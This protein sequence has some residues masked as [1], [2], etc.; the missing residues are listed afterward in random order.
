[1]RLHEK[2]WLKQAVNPEHKG[3][4]TP[5]SKKTC[6]PRRKAL[7]RRFKS[8]DLHQEES[9]IDRLIPL[10]PGRV[11]HCGKCPCPKCGHVNKE[12]ITTCAKCGAKT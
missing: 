7:A 11:E 10:P 6:T 3:Y 5:M 12:G 2:K 4:C 9:L 8:G 1:M